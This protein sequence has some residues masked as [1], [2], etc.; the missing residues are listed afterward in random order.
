MH[1]LGH[2]FQGYS[3]RNKPVIDYL[4]P[5]MEAAEVHSMSPST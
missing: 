2:A 5:T 4:T 1:E 3:S